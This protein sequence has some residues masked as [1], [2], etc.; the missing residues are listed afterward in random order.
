MV[1]RRKR[2]LDTETI[3]DAALACVD[4][5][6]RLAMAELATRLGVSTS[7]IYHHFSGRT[8]IIEAL[9]ERM[10]TAID[11]PPLDGSDWS[12]QVG[13]WMRGYR[14][15]LAEHPSL[16]PLLNE[17]TMTAGSVL[18]GYERI[19]IL[20]RGAGVPM[21][22]VVLWISVLDCYALGAALD[23][24][25]PDDVWRPERD[26]LPTLVDAITAAPRGRDRAD[27][28]FDVGLDALV[29]GLRRRLGAD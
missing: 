25:A 7:S 9:R 26:D 3:L 22:D 5:T 8:A 13:Q 6:G 27:E 20:L 29:T 16:I 28:A 19:A 12:E 15:A 14:R 17:Q 2:L 21:R 23:L 18:H 24:A 1:R 10:A 4:N 11:P